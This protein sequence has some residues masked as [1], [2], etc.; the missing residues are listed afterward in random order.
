MNHCVLKPQGCPY[1][2]APKKYERELNEVTEEP[3]SPR[4]DDEEKRMCPASSRYV[5]PSTMHEPLT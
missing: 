5:V 2:P 4:V 1:E 3:E